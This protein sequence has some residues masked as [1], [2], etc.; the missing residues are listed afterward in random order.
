MSQPILVVALNLRGRASPQ[1]WE[2]L[3]VGRR[4]ADASKSPLV[5][6]LAGGGPEAARELVERGADRVLWTDDDRLQELNEELHAQAV[7]QA[8]AKE[9]P[10]AVLLPSNV[11]GRS[12]A[13]R[14]AVK[15]GAGLAMDVSEIEAAGQV[16]RGAYSGNLVADVEF[17]APVRVLTV[18]AMLFA[19]AA[20][21]AGRS[22][23]VQE[24]KF[25]P[26][27]TRTE[28]KSF[29]A[30]EAGEIDLGSAERIVSGGRGVG[31]KDKFSAIREL[32]HALGAAVGASRAAVDS[33]WIPYRHQVGL[34]GRTVRPKLYV[35]CGIS[36][37]IQHLAGMSG[38]NAIVAINT[39]P[40]CPMMQQATVA[41]AGDMFELIPL[42]VAEVK[43]RKGAAVAA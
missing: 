39:D 31:G 32:A 2:L 36:G 18:T 43:K 20:R 24:L 9:N 11:A 12:L 3:S 35:A 6:V 19:P 4:L 42:I 16:K 13:C 5:A 15:L 7:L 33:G 21:Q 29:Q 22:G 27:P 26:G 34:T 1:T 38:A 30:E 37:Q 14:L 8:A 25:A 28:F 17:Q 23:E 41:V 40:E 10:A